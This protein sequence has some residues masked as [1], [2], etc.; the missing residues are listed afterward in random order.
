MLSMFYNANRGKR[1]RPM[2]PSDFNPVEQAKKSREPQTPAQMAAMAKAFV[3]ASGG[4]IK[5]GKKTSS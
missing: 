5:S 1:S 4:V 3:I 2:S